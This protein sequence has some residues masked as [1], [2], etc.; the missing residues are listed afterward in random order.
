MEYQYNDKDHEYFV[1]KVKLSPV[2]TIIKE[3]LDPYRFLPKMTQERLKLLHWQGKR[4][5]ALHKAIEYDL[6]RTLDIDS[7]KGVIK[8]FFES[9]IR[10]KEFFNIRLICVEKRLF[11]PRLGYAGTQDL[12]AIVEIKGVDYFATI[13]FKSS[14][15][16][17]DHFRHQPPAYMLG[18]YEP[19]FS[20]IDRYK[21]GVELVELEEGTVVLPIKEEKFIILLLKEDGSMPLPKVYS[22]H[23]NKYEQVRDWLK[24]LHKYHFNNGGWDPEKLFGAQYA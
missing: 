17:W 20:N 3:V 12:R 18:W 21:V 11:N 14:M 6:L 24:I 9:W 19:Q 15:N 4:G 2:T 7:V 13:D 23:E 5:T 10:A 16:Y 8:P 22:S 1:N